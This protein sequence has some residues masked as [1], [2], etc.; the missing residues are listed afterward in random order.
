MVGF[1]E[2]SLL[3]LDLQTGLASE[4]QWHG[5]GE[6]EK[7]FFDTANACLVSYAG[8]LSVVEYG[9]DEVTASVRTEHTSSHLLSVRINERPPRQGEDNPD[10]PRVDDQ[11]GEN[12]KIAYLL[13]TQTVCVKN[14]HT[15]ASTTI[16]H[17]TK[18]DFLELNSR[19]NLLLFRDKRRVLHLFDVERQTRT[20]L[21]N[22]CSYV[23]WVPNSDVVVAQ[24]RNSMCVWYNIHAPDQVMIREIKGDIEGIERVNGKTEGELI[25]YLSRREERLCCIALELQLSCRRRFFSPWSALLLNN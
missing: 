23:Q 8:E 11:D 22:Y 25:Y 24:N 19:G 1:T 7:F 20:A 5:N 10:T 2:G 6:S 3:L 9:N 15:Q 14:L 18:I 16:N 4:I 17:D 12:K 13:D 21:L